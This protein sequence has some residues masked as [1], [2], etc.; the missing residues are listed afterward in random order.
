MCQAKPL[1][2]GVTFPITTIV[3][4]PQADI[5]SIY[6]R[7]YH[8]LLFASHYEAWGMPVMEAMASGIPVVTSACMGVDMFCHSGFNCLMVPPT[9]TLAMAKAVCTLIEDPTVRALLPV[10][11]LLSVLGAVFNVLLVACCSMQLVLQR[12]AERLWLSSR[13]TGRQHCW[14]THC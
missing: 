7:G 5:P 6:Q 14:K 12:M 8:V 13:G 1:C 2:D 4:P 3:S 10:V 11:N 9:D